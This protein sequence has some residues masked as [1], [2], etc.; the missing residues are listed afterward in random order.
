M[1]LLTFIKQH[2][3]NHLSLESYHFNLVENKLAYTNDSC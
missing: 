3:L 1:L 2:N